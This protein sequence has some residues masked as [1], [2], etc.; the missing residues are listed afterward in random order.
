MALHLYSR[1]LR[2]AREREKGE[3]LWKNQRDREEFISF[4]G[5]AAWRHRFSLILETRTI[6]DADVKSRVSASVFAH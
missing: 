1:S 6:A 2:F 4:I 3:F 5:N